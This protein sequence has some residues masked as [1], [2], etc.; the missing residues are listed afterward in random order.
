MFSRLN[1][2]NSQKRE[3]FPSHF[4]NALR[5]WR[6]RGTRNLARNRACW[7]LMMAPATAKQGEPKGMKNA[8]RG[9]CNQSFRRTCNSR[10]DS[11]STLVTVTVFMVAIFGFAALSVDVANV[12]HQQRNE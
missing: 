3:E 1:A 2:P 9:T 4:R 8:N 6:L 10:R 11:G 7:P 5:S 12:F